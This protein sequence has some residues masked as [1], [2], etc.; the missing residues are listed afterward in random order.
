MT[1]KQNCKKVNKITVKQHN[2]IENWFTLL[3]SLYPSTLNSL[4]QT[5]MAL[6]ISNDKWKNNRTRLEKKVNL[7]KID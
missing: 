1:I 7:Y 6:F 5:Q 3:I 2:V 4:T